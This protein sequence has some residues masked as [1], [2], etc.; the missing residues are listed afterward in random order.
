MVALRTK[1]TLINDITQVRLNLPQWKPRDVTDR[2]L[3]VF[4]FHT[5]G[6][7][8]VLVTE[9]EDPLNV[10]VDESVDKMLQHLLE[11]A[12]KMDKVPSD[13]AIAAAL[14]DRAGE[15]FVKVWSEYMEDLGL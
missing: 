2:L 15:S 10:L 14:R 12:A 3:S 9:T 13:S 7:V 5:K 6:G 11:G 4:K 8:V 1:S